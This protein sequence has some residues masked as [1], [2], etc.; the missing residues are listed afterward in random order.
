[1]TGGGK[2]PDTPEL[3]EPNPLLNKF[4]YPMGDSVLSESCPAGS[5]DFKPKPEVTWIFVYFWY[6][7]VVYFQCSC[8]YLNVKTLQLGPEK[9][10]KVFCVVCIVMNVNTWVL[11]F[12]VTNYDTLS[13]S[14]MALLLGTSIWGSTAAVQGD[15]NLC[16]LCSSTFI[17]Y[18]ILLCLHS[19]VIATISNQLATLLIWYMGATYVDLVQI[20]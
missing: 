13:G 17:N 19:V 7:H 15:N 8:G 20:W 14:Y 5:L 18:Q 4:L 1:M 11:Y 2:V 9:K 16:I 3:F 12:I 6:H 10:S